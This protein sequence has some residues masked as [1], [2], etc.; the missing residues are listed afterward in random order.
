MIRKSALNIALLQRYLMEYKMCFD[1]LKNPSGT[2]RYQN[3][4]YE[5]GSLGSG[6]WKIYT[7][8]STKLNH[9]LELNHDI[10]W[11]LQLFKDKMANS[12]FPF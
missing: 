5:R 6:G 2:E 7:S 1:E 12:L 4:V 10:A 8:P 11:R 3:I 9:W